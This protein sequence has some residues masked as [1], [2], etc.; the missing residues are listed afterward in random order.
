MS[1]QG[2][3]AAVRQWLRERP[4]WHFTGDI[5]DGLGLTG[6]RARQPYAFALRSASENG[7]LDR[8]GA[9]KSTRYRYHREP[10]K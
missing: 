9:Q 7:L 10:M 1:A 6:W 3:A 4:G 8:T 2:K 5:L